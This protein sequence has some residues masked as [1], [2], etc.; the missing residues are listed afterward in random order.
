MNDIH[1]G[2]G[3]AHLWM[4]VVHILLDEIGALKQRMM[5]YG[6][7]RTVA[8]SLLIILLEVMLGV[9]AIPL[10]IFANHKKYPH[11]SQ[12]GD[13][14]VNQYR[15]RRVISL[16]ALV[17]VSAVT[18]GSLFINP[19]VYSGGDPPPPTPSNPGGIA[20]E[21]VLGQANYT[22][23]GSNRGGAVAA[24]TLYDP[25][26]L[27]VDSS[28]IYVADANNH[29]VLIWNSTS[30]ASGANAD[31]VLGQ[32]NM[33]SGSANRGATVAANTFDTPY[34]VHSD[35][36]KIYVADFTNNRVLIWN[37]T[38]P[39][40][41]A[42]ADIVL[43][44]ANMTSGSANR[45]GAV[46][47]N[48]L[49]NP[50]G[51]YSD[52][53]K[54]YVADSFNHRVLIWNST[55]PASGADADIVL[56][57]ANMT[58]GSANRGGT[59]AA[60]TLSTPY[61]VSADNSRIYV[62]DYTNNR[63]LIWNSTSPASG[64]NADVVLGQ[65]DFISGGA[66]NP[67]NMLSGPYR[68]V[69][70]NRNIYVSDNG[71]RRVL[72]Y[73]TT[74]PASGRSADALVGRSSFTDNTI[75]LTDQQTLNAPDS[76]AVSG[77]KLYVGDDSDDRVLRFDLTAANPT[78][79]V[80]TPAASST[81]SLNLNTGS[82]FDFS[83]FSIFEA[84]TG[85]YLAAD[86]TLT[87]NTAVYQA[88]SS[89]WG[90]PLWVVLL[91]PGGPY[92]FSAAGRY[93][94]GDDSATS[95]AST[96][97]ALPNQPGVPTTATTTDPTILA[98]TLVGNSNSTATTFSLYNITS[99]N[100][101]GANGASA[102]SPVYRSTS[103]WGAVNVSGLTAN[104]AYL[105][106]S[107]AK[108]G[109]G[110]LSATSTTSTIR[111][112]EVQGGQLITDD[113]F[114]ISPTGQTTAVIDGTPGGGTGS[115]SSLIIPQT[116]DFMSRV[117]VDFSR[118]IQNNIVT[119]SLPINLSR[120][121]TDAFSN[122]HAFIPAGITMRA[123]SGTW[124]G[125]LIAPT[126]K[127]ITSVGR[128]SFGSVRSVMEVGYPGL[129]L[130]LS[131]PSS[132]RF[133]GQAGLN[134]AYQTP[135]GETVQITLRCNSPTDPSNIVGDGECY[136]SDGNDMVVWTKHFTEFFMVDPSGGA[137]APTP[138]TIVRSGPGFTPQ[139][140]VIN[141]GAAETNTREV[142]MTLNIVGANQVALSN[143]E[144]FLGA[145]FVPFKNNM[146]WL[147]SAG[148]GEK[149]VYARFRTD[150]GGTAD[151][152]AAIRLTGQ[153]T[154][155]AVTTT[156]TT[157]TTP[158]TTTPTTTATPKETVKSL[159]APAGKAC[160]LAI[161]QP[162]K[163][164]HSRAVYYITEACTK[165]LFRSGL[166]YFSY[167]P[168]WNQVQITDKKSLAAVPNDKQNFM[169]LGPLLPLRDGALVKVT[170]NPKVYLIEGIT[171]R[172]VPDEATFIS[173]YRNW[174]LV[175]DVVFDLL[176][177]YANGAPLQSVGSATTSP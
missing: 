30:P 139:S 12:Y 97:Y 112:T 51:V 3:L 77:G 126:S 46:A 129:T 43:G 121:S 93:V 150:K 133:Q 40:S 110:T 5:K 157:I 152:T 8:A 36:S 105:F 114:T 21:L 74:A 26:G 76:L 19:V 132:L 10:Y 7:V 53:S 162:Y 95:T 88:T 172:W 168:A 6:P 163:T 72:I 94:V 147:L 24:N 69:S 156:S 118:M 138:P 137:P 159:S 78:L 59:V 166:V 52:G 13:Y 108:N 153:P 111:F 128:P 109:A 145:S 116:V 65:S 34:S 54:I 100:F 124:N 82:N 176:D 1:G 84:Y 15:V 20:A 174:K 56:G 171:R 83:E 140:L 17:G 39:A 122:F 146:K 134:P 142:T 27:S 58:S 130:T 87:S 75:Y 149:K 155:Q 158:T 90:T 141:N 101:I 2:S 123:T 18:F 11:F 120:A 96:A 177:Q 91:T 154:D 48:T 160:P 85:K 151:A 107:V 115:F 161:G 9:F 66:G 37:S 22:G 125:T 143:S 136:A 89:A 50:R 45:G 35:G 41:G 117:T 73:R 63:V 67:A 104:Q 47:A 4:S 144:D 92:T 86:W 14:R 80:A 16:A 170:D 32:A 71:N 165:R 135:A 44:Q 62:T 25:F 167:Y 164:V 102:A 98:V 70:D 57:Q 106:S 42:D 49:A 103:T 55:S 175:I 79:T 64:A 131:E 113:S 38:S 23:T 81:F 119:T 99:G 68:A 31:I 61:H 28:K 29:R 127:A 33:T 148:N 173:L 169:P 60:N